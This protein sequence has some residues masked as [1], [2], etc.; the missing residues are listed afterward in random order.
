MD[1]TQTQ[2]CDIRDPQI[3]NIVL[4]LIFMQRYVICNM[5]ISHL[6]GWYRYL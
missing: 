3:S 2:R 1:R 4:I 5:Y 6:D